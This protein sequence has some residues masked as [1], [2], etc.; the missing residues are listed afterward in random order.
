MRLFDEMLSPTFSAPPKDMSLW[1][2]FILAVVKAS[3]SSSEKS[4]GNYVVEQ[5]RLAD[6]NLGLAAS[7]ELDKPLLDSRPLEQILDEEDFPTDF[8]SNQIPPGS[9]T[10]S[11]KLL[12]IFKHVWNLKTWTDYSKRRLHYS[13]I[14]GFQDLG[15]WILVR[16]FIDLMSTPPYNVS[17]TP[18]LHQEMIQIGATTMM[19]NKLLRLEPETRSNLMRDMVKTA[20]RS[21]EE[22]KTLMP[23]DDLN[24][25]NAQ[26]DM[27]VLCVRC[28]LVGFDC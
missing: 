4:L 12:A 6:L 27:V 25:K 14:R 5:H 23:K 28:G 8:Y 2:E 1:L 9:I 11:R 26:T 19:P 10:K 20:E 16:K 22:L 24:F 7:A 18:L 3:P 21:Y 15:Q 13:M 17:L